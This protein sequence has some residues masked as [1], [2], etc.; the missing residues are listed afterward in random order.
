MSKSDM[1]SMADH[2]AVKG[3]LAVVFGV[4][5]VF[6]PHLTLSTLVYLFSGY[7]LAM[8]VLSLISSFSGGKNDSMG[9]WLMVLVA[10]VEVCIGVYLFRHPAV[11]FSTLILLAS[12]V[13]IVRGLFTLVAPFLS[14]GASA[15]STLHMFLGL[16]S[17]VAGVVLLFQPASSGVAFVWIL[18]IYALVTGPLL[19]A[20]SKSIRE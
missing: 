9:T 13:L 14:D 1:S 19:L 2:L 5:A 17:V 10:L 6:W 15:G 4:A 11:S 18:G 3:F 12:I 7:I 16:V 20:I 8:G